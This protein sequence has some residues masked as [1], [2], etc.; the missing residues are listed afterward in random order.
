[1]NLYSFYKREMDIE[2]TITQLQESF[3]GKPW[4]GTSV[5]DS[6]SAISSDFWN[7]KPKSTTHSIAELVVHIIDWRGFVIEKLQGNASFSIEM[8]SEQDWRKG[9]SVDSEGDK[10]IL[11]NELVETQNQLISLLETKPDSWLIELVAGGKYK[12][13][14]MI[15]GIVPHDIYHVGQ[16]N[17]IYS[18]SK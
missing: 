1:M 4:F 17:L 16:I 3:N 10:E 2:D 15:R 11:M 5:W 12:N 18:Q 9:V 14:Y 8:N 7:T 13:E 6:L